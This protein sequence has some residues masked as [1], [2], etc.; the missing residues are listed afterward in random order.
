MI[1]DDEEKKRAHHWYKTP[2]TLEA[3][4]NRALHMVEVVR[5]RKV[6]RKAAQ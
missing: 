2:E 1:V 3:A 4:R 5:D 6:V